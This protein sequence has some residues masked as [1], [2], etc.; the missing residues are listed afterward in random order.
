MTWLGDLFKRSFIDAWNTL[1]DT[2]NDTIK[3]VVPNVFPASVV[4]SCLHAVNNL[5]NDLFEPVIGALGQS[6]GDKVTGKV[7][8]SLE[9]MKQKIFDLY[10]KPLDDITADLERRLKKLEASTSGL[11]PIPTTLEEVRKAIL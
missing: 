1:Q 6:V 9:D 3:Q 2:I 10:V 7:E 5:L 4:R 11:F 8:D